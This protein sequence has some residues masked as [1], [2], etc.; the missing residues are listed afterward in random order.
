MSAYYDTSYASPVRHGLY[1]TWERACGLCRSLDGA[2]E[3]G[4][5]DDQATACPCCRRGADQLGERPA[6]HHAG[7]YEVIRP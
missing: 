3:T 6:C 1:A 7:V 4:P 2:R 5:S